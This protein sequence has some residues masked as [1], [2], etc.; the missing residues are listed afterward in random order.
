MSWTPA[1]PS[2]SPEVPGG[3]PAVLCAG[4]AGV[5]SLQRSANSSGITEPWRLKR[6]WYRQAPILIA[7]P[8]RRYPSDSRSFVLRPSTESLS[9]RPTYRATSPTPAVLR[10]CMARPARRADVCR[11]ASTKSRSFEC[12]LASL[13]SRSFRRR[14]SPRV[15]TPAVLRRAGRRQTAGVECRHGPTER[16]SG[17]VRAPTCQTPSSPCSATPA[18]SSSGLS[19]PS[20]LNGPLEC[21]HA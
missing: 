8:R 12:C 19:S 17:L 13:G 3:T 18:V 4:C 15:R 2:A 10:S 14:A 6:G 1:L 11:H 5:T 9:E 16:R 7:G 21:V 20:L